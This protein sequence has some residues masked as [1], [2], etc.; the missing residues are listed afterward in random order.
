MRRVVLAF[1]V[2]G[3]VGLGACS[4]GGSVLSNSQTPQSVIVTVG[5]PSNIARVLPGASLPMSATGVTGAQ[6]G[7]AGTNRFAW[8]AALVTSGQYVAN[9]GGQTKACA[10]ITYTPMGGAAAPYGTDFSIYI[11]ID[12]TN[13]SN[14][15]FAA[16][17]SI[18]LPAGAPVGSTITTSYPY[19]VQVSATALNSSGQSTGAT[20]TI[21]VAV[22]NPLNPEQ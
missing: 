6:N 13:Q 18:P 22:V 14:I 15:V 9:T 19:C 2:L 1:A 7:V 3:A 10:A 20:G 8:T 11:T 4:G 12:P 17:T 21:T 16:P 5:A